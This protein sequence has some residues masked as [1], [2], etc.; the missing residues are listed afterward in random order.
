MYHLYLAKNICDK[1]HVHYRALVTLIFHFDNI[2]TYKNKI[3]CHSYIRNS[4]EHCKLMNGANF[5]KN[6]FNVS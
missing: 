6:K 1:L 4:N 2:I 5:E 3:N